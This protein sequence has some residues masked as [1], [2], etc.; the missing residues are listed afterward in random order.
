[1]SQAP[2]AEPGRDRTIRRILV[3]LDASADSA[4]A[5]EA[6]TALAALFGAE[7]QGLYVEDLNFV[8]LP[9]LSMV[10]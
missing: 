8:R 3:A 4:A 2:A 6:A 9:E 7:L 1:M 5:L 10:T